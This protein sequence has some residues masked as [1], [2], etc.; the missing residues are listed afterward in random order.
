MFNVTIGSAIEH[1][2]VNTTF[3]RCD[4]H[5][6]KNHTFNL[7][8]A[9]SS[10]IKARAYMGSGLGYLAEQVV[11]NSPDSDSY[12]FDTCNCDDGYNFLCIYGDNSE[13]ALFERDQ[14]NSTPT[15]GGAGFQFEPAACK[16]FAGVTLLADYGFTAIEKSGFGGVHGLKWPGGIKDG[17]GSDFLPGSVEFRHVEVCKIADSKGFMVFSEADALSVWPGYGV[18]VELGLGNVPNLG[19]TNDF[20]T[21]GVGEVDCCCLEDN[22][23]AIAYIKGNRVWTRIAEISGTAISWGTAVE[24]NP[25]SAT[26][27]HVRCRAISPKYYVI[28]Y[29]DGLDR[30]RVMLCYVDDT[31]SIVIL[32]E[33]FEADAIRYLDMAV[34]YQPSGTTP[35]GA[36]VVVCY[37]DTDDGWKGKTRILTFDR[38]QAAPLMFGNPI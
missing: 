35:N 22:K 23:V 26:G 18:V 38:S 3:N 27:E 7:V 14:I 36:E 16:N 17:N 25:G 6:D 19:G 2:S 4:N 12:P 28:T 9:A 8:Y 21:S 37:T 29:E 34:I 11:Y 13:D 15:W 20:E 10:E 30:G 5:P 32:D 24:M 1:S 33:V 31:T